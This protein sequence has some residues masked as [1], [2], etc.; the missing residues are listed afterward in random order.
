MNIP[1]V[2]LAA[3][4]RGIEAEV[5]K[6][7]ESVVRAQRFIL[8]P[9]VEEAEK[10]I[11]EY[12]GTPFGVGVA[13]GT[14]ALILSLRALG[15]GPGDEVITTPFTFY[16]TASSVVHAGAT[17]VFA[18]IEPDTCL[19]SAEAVEAAV[20][21]RTRAM[22]PVHLFG[23]CADMGRIMEIAQRHGLAVVE[24]ACQAIGAE[25][26]GRRAGAI[27]DAGA[28]SFYPSK[29]LGGYGD[30]GMV[31]TRRADAAEN[32]RLLRVHG[33]K[34]EYRHEVIGYNSRLDTIQAAVLLC[35]LP[36]LEQWGKARRKNAAIYGRRF[37][38]TSVRPLA[39]RPGR[40]HV[41]NNYVVRVPRRDELMAHLK[42]LAIGCAVYYPEPLSKMACFARCVGGAAFPAAEEAART[43]LAIPAYPEM[44]EEMV[45]SVADA[46]LAFFGEGK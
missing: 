22:I 31:V 17:P 18:D 35:K 14:D 2:D 24:D 21:A 44:T 23:Q 25:F 46:V 10:K 42:A 12:C 26:E 7:I 37:A 34:S 13:S 39:L 27:G 29:N 8:G 33:A 43:C 30:G 32:L 16:A 20:T 38:G 4:F 11:A 9:E 6:R 1:L 19:I 15:I 28:L 5:L 40:K 41:Y 3:Q 36:H 45:E